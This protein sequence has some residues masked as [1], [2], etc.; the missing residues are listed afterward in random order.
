MP[1]VAVESAGGWVA[2]P[3]AGGWVAF[4]IAVPSLFVS[5]AAPPAAPSVSPFNEAH[6][7]APLGLLLRNGGS[8]GGSVVHL[9]VRRAKVQ[10]GL[11]QAQP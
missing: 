5:R 2:I 8:G 11:L 7:R 1:L 10:Q 4:A 6:Y 3:I 9:E